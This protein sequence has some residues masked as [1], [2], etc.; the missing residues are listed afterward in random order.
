MALVVKHYYTNPK[1]NRTVR[2]DSDE[3]V[4]AFSE[5]QTMFSDDPNGQV[6]M[7]YDDG[8]L[9]A[10]FVWYT[11]EIEFWSDEFRDSLPD[12]VRAGA[13][14]RAADRQA[15]LQASWETEKR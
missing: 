7:L 9:L 8:E 6:S 5:L 2:F 14:S 11:Q 13:E 10:S 1:N 3:I 15:E 12:D 4:D